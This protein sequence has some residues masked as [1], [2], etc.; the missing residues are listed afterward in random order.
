MSGSTALVPTIVRRSEIPAI[1][2]VVI[3]GEEHLLGVLKDFRKDPRLAAFIPQTSSLSIS[4]VR[5]TPGEELDT[6]VHPVESMILVSEGDVRVTGDLAGPLLTA[7]DALL[8]PKGCRHGFVGAGAS[9]FWGL[10]IQFEPT[11]LYD[12]PLRPKVSFEDAL[13]SEPPASLTLDALLERNDTY[14]RQFALNP[15][16]ALARTGALDHGEPR[17]RFLDCFQVWSNSFQRMVQLR[18]TISENPIYAK[19]AHAHA[20]DERDH[21]LDLATRRDAIRHVWDPTLEATCSWF[22]WKLFAIDEAERVV[23]MHLVI[24][25]SATVFYQQMQCLHLSPDTAP[26]GEVHVAADHDHVQ[27][28]VDRLRQHGTHDYQ[29]L[30]LV[31][32]QGWK[33]LNAMFRQIHAL[34]TRS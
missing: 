20:L 16:F 5:L 23:L 13:A 22:L 7:G 12:D 33:M 14:L 4:W 34:I 31:Q 30:M 32:E 11:G 1:E 3:D 26:H 18:A 25:A 10:S 17:N 19:L 21:N 9:G 29:R 8:V 27:M 6:H 2:S 15:L 24:E 28:G